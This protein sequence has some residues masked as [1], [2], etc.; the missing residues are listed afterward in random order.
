M[1]PKSARGKLK[2]LN[3]RGPEGNY[4]Q[5]KG[6]QQFSNQLRLKVKVSCCRSRS[7]VPAFVED[8]FQGY[9]VSF[10]EPNHLA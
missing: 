4:R 8:Y 6:C 7:R 5:S 2:P 1:L 9:S 3:I 10:H